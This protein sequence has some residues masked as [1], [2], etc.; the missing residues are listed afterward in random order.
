MALALCPV[1]WLVQLRSAIHQGEP[2]GS[3]WVS[4][5]LGVRVVDVSPAQVTFLLLLLRSSIKARSCWVALWG[6]WVNGLRFHHLFP[7]DPGH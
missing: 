2:P 4:M 1:L 3:S 5:A 7:L 6:C